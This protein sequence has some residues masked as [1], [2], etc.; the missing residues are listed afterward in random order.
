MLKTCLKHDLRSSRRSTVLLLIIG[1]S[2]ALLGG[3][4][5]RG[6]NAT[7]ELASV[8]FLVV[9]SMFG[10]V[11]GIFGM[12]GAFM[13]LYAISFID[14]WQGFFTDQGYLTFTLPVKRSTLYL[15]K[16]IV[17]TLVQ[18][19]AMLSFF[20]GILWLTMVIPEP[21]APGGFFNTDIVESLG[22]SIAGLFRANGAW[23]VLWILPSLVL[24]V[25]ALFFSNGLI[26]L[27]MVI[28]GTRFQKH[29]V[30]KGVGIFYLLSGAVSFAALFGFL[31]IMAAAAEIGQAAV[32]L[33]GAVMGLSITGLIAIFAMLFGCL[34]AILHYTAIGLLE[35]KINLT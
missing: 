34:A 1:F 30:A 18:L 29:R 24:L 7:I 5:M 33:G 32:A 8:S 28:A 22:A 2:A 12:F 27:C 14:L 3:L 17:A 6:F 9:P 35:R 25:A 20:L 23:T 11:I 10:G 21:S 15:S 4:C 26:F 19:I 13:G 31:F 16:V